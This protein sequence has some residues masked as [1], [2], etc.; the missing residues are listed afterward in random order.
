M[1]RILTFLLW[2]FLAAGLVSCEPEFV[3]GSGGITE[4]P[5]PDDNDN[6]G[7]TPE[8]DVPGTTV[9]PAASSG[10]TVEPS[11]PNAD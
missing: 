4:K 7:G 11:V 5:A 9:S 1:K 10:I 8:P 2:A 6:T 3:E